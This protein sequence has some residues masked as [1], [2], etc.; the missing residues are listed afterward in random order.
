M[1]GNASLPTSIASLDERSQ[2]LA[3]RGPAIDELRPLLGDGGELH[4]ELGPQHLARRIQVL[5]RPRPALA[6]VV[7]MT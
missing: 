3:R 1:N 2:Q 6:V 4:V 7:V 5:H